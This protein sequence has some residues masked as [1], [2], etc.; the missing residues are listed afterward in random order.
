MSHS[1]ISI[2]IPHIGCPCRCSFC[3]QV[4]ITGHNEMPTE[5]D[6]NNAVETALKSKRYQKSDG[7]IAFFGGSFTAIDRNLMTRY[8]EIGYSHILKGNAES[9]RIST[10]PD[11][12]NQ[13]ILDI[14]KQYGVKSIELGAQSMS[15]D[16][17]T[18]NHR[19]H[20]ARD[21]YNAS[22]LI[23][24]NGFELGL[25][26]MMGLHKSNFKTDLYTAN[27]FVKIAPETVRI[28]PTVVLKNTLLEKLYL[29]GEYQPL[30]VEEAA[31]NG[32][33]LLKLFY[34]NNINVIRFGLHSIEKDSFVAGA[35]HPALNEIAQ[36]YIYREIIDK[37]ITNK[38]FY[39]VFVKDTELSKAKGQKKSNIEF[40]KKKHIF[41]DIVPDKMM[42]KYEIKLKERNESAE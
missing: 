20:T 33:K 10:R 19:G 9:I 8:L 22:V 17:L 23:K 28:Y 37:S 6:I 26:M 36:G 30:S 13:E 25:Q 12:I 7:Q 1:N 29:N 24:N 27:E 18:A 14:L 41:L 39:T 2:F 38:G 21:V 34:D 35:F 32:S 11:A 16:V 31:R 3:N 42:G 15:D 5:N 4:Y 40:F